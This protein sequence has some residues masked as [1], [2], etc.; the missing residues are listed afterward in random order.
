MDNYSVLNILKIF[1]KR[2][3]K[4][5]KKQIL[6]LI[7]IVIFSAFSETLSLASAF[8]FLQIIIDQENIW[9]NQLISSLFE[10]FGLGKND[11][12]IFPICIVFSLS[13]IIAANLK[14]YNL[15]FS[16]K[17]AAQITSDLSSQCFKQSLYQ[18]YEKQIGENSSNLIKLLS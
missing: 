7:I 16:G 11:D 13:A 15:W 4:K 5:R 1:L 8:S 6:F 18:D 9:K 10:T 2:L 3:N 14:I 17:L 12:L